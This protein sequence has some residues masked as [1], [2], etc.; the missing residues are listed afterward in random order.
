MDELSPLFQDI[1]FRERLRGYDVAEVDAYVGR[2]ARAVA[3]AQGRITELQQ[4]VAAAE[5]RELQR[6]AAIDSEETASTE[7]VSTEAVSRVLVLAQRT[8]DAA[9][10]EAQ[11]EASELLERACADAAAARS[12]ADEYASRVLAEAETDRRRATADAEVAAAEAI[13]HERDRATEAIAELDQYRAF[14]AE[15]IEILERHLAE[16]RSVLATSLSGL[17]DL[18]DSPEAF[19]APAVPA[20]SGAVAPATLDAPARR[21]GITEQTAEFEPITEVTVASDGAAEVEDA[22]LLD[23]SEPVDAADEEM[24]DSEV[25]GVT[26]SV[27]TDAPPPPV[28]AAVPLGLVDDDVSSVPLAKE[29]CAPPLLFTVAD[30]AADEVSHEWSRDTRGG[31]DPSSESVAVV[32]DPALFEESVGVASA[33][34]ADPFLEQLR[35]AVARGDSEEFDEEALA[36]FF[37]GD[38]DEESRSWFPNRR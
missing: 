12:E 37:D 6:L 23:M 27:D 11:E 1:E 10:A 13:A 35:D 3:A 4:R 14:L 26:A 36:A 19:R 8:A 16:C 31:S 15:D 34:A 7:T 5:A 32:A 20:L 18:L 25:P 29:E 21:P 17:A 22:P 30:L 9:V 28:D 38:G 24:V 2:V 33:T